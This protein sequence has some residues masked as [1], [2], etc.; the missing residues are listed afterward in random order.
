MEPRDWA[1]GA[2]ALGVALRALEGRA[3]SLT[4][5]LMMLPVIGHPNRHSTGPCFVELRDRMFLNSAA[6]PAQWVI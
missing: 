4:H 6:S 5:H 1:H 2:P 3:M